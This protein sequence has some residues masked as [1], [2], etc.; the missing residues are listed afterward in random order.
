[1]Y[2]PK[3][4]IQSQDAEKIK[5]ASCMPTSYLLTLPPNFLSDQALGL[6]LNPKINIGDIKHMVAYDKDDKIFICKICGLRRTKKKSIRNHIMASIN[7]EWQKQAVG[8][9]EATQSIHL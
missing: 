9:F 1:M 8:E 4:F 5:W 7:N 3:L 6:E 2:T